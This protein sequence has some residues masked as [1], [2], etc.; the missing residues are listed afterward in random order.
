[1]AAVQPAGRSVSAPPT[2]VSRRAGIRLLLGPSSPSRLGFILLGSILLSFFEILGLLAIIPLVELLSSKNSTGSLTRLEDWFGHPTRS[3]LALILALIAMGSF[4]TK[5]V[6]NVIFQWWSSGYVFRQEA[7]T[8]GDLLDRYMRAPY[9]IHLERNTAQFVRTLMDSTSQAYSGYISA[10]INFMSE[11]VVSSVI[12]VALIVIEPL[13]AA[14]AGAYFLVVGLAYVKLVSRRSSEAGVALSELSTR[15]YKTARQALGGVKEAKIRQRQ[16]YFVG[17][18]SQARFEM[19][20]VKRLVTFLNQLPKYFLEVSFITGVGLISILVASRSDS[21]ETLALLAL[22]VAAGFRL[23]PSMVKI[24]SS[25]SS[26]RTGRSGFDLVVN[27]LLAFPT[28]ATTEGSDFNPGSMPITNTLTIDDISFSYGSRETLVLDH[29]SFSVA[30]GESFGVVGASGAGKSTLI[31]LLLGLHLPDAGKI[32]VDGSD[33]VTNMPGWQS[34]I[35]LVPQD[36]YLLDDTL[37]ANIAFGI[38]AVNVDRTLL[39]QVIVQSQLSQLVDDLP[40][41]LDTMIGERGVRISGG[42]RQR[43]GIARSLYAR[44]SLLILDEATSA[45]DNETEL[46]I[47]ETIESLHGTLTMIV[48]AHRL[49]TI[50]KC[51]RILFLEDGRVRDIGSF[52]ELV[53]R[54]PEFA[55]LTRLAAVH[56][57]DPDSQ[58]P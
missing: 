6:C 25:Y 15:S 1:M 56:G 17:Q 30:R 11:A 51:D 57:L 48:V 21:E 50:R 27:D 23:L 35:G 22:F 28:T 45:L 47:S 41:G 4:V 38:D 53:G 2:G 58:Q 44:P 7:R 18:Y 36:V 24:L 32:L 49:S 31:D 39:A 29:V 13:A 40:S 33:I 26:I 16:D 14:G 19:A 46:R 55:N 34:G 9:W 12:I 20:K 52:D 42:Q 54:D 8:T 10:T 3:R 37:S 5:A 43:L